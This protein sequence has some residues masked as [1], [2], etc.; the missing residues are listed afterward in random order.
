[1]ASSMK[2]TGSNQTQARLNM[3]LTLI[4]FAL[5]PLIVVALAIGIVTISSSRKELKNYN[6]DSLVQVIEGVGNSFDTMVNTNETILKACATAPIYRQALENPDDAEIIAKAQQYTLDYFGSLD[7]WEGLYLS[8]WETQVLT[9]PNEGVIG[10]VLREGDRLTSLQ[11]SMLSADDGVFNTGIMQSPASGQLIMSI[12][13]PIMVDGEPAGFV[14]GAFYVQ[15]IAQHISD[16]S[17]LNLDSAYV[18]FVDHDGIMLHHPD[19]EKL[20]QPVENEAVKGLVEQIG[21]GQHPE[22]DIVEYNY[23]GKIKYAGYYVGANEAY[24]AVLSADEDDVLANIKNIRRTTLAIAIVSILLFTV[25]AMLIERLISVP[26]IDIS[27][28]IN[29]LGTGDVNAQCKAKTHIKETV[30]LLNSFYVLRDALSSSIGSVKNAAGVLDQSIVSVD[31]MTAGNVESVSQINTAINE[32]AQTSQSVASSAQTMAEKA[33]YLGDNIETL[34]ENVKNL[35]EASQTIKNANNDATD[36]MRNVYAG[37]N[38]SVEAMHDIN[39]KINETNSAISDI[40]TAI[41]AIESI[42]EQTNLLSL[43]ASIEAARAGE[44]GRGFAVVAD[45]IRSLADSSADSAKEIKQIIENVMQLSSGTVDISNR[46]YEVI[47][48]EQEDIKTAQDKF[49]VLS[50][51]VEASIS[52]IEIIRQMAHTLDGIKVELANS[53][54]DLGA[55]SQELGASAQEVAASCQTVNEACLDT[56]RSAEQMKGINEDMS[57]SIA[58]FRL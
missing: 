17:G 45:E 57:R 55:I 32:V 15:N 44:A 58:F 11:D 54:T 42:A 53:T 24:I 10:M 51:S 35:Y 13:T 16:V 31:N 29:K 50:D 6:H 8:T 3:R 30:N 18:Y 40:G 1:M 27:E 4:L 14:G 36:C 28:A 22:P 26:I 49:N 39:S 43:N 19:P 21:Q 20:G 48:R 52:E 47:T 7:G 2:G 56:Q 41:Q 37:A 25:L 46:V 9:H 5:I 12:Y 38:E 34:N 33:A 23:R